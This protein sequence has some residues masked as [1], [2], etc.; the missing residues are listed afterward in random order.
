MRHSVVLYRLAFRWSSSNGLNTVLPNCAGF[1][2]CDIIDVESK[3]S[4]RRFIKLAKFPTSPPVAFPFSITSSGI[5]L[6]KDDGMEMKG[7]K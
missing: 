7:L 6:H 4:S 1:Q 5:V 3:F 2:V